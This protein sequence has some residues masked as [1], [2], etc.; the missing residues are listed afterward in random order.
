VRTGCAWTLGRGSGS[1]RSG[2]RALWLKLRAFVDAVYD[3]LGGLDE[4]V[5]S[6]GPLLRQGTFKDEDA[7][8]AAG[9][10]AL[11][12]CLPFTR[13][14]ETLIM[15][16]LTANCGTFV[17]ELLLRRSFLARLGT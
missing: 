6:C 11:R 17:G 13:V 14:R 8:L 15:A 4:L 10:V 12:R 9:L 7:D 16:A 3:L 1:S 5:V 2:P